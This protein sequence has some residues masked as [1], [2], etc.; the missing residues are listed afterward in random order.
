MVYKYEDL[1]ITSIM[2]FQRQSE[3]HNVR[4]KFLE[5]IR[6]QDNF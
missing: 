6:H 4:K 5:A 2:K 3:L 1:E